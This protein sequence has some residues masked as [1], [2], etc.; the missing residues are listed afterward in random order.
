[1][2][3]ICYALKEEKSQNSSGNQCLHMDVDCNW[4]CNLY[5]IKNVHEVAD[6]LKSLSINGFIVTP[7]SYG[8]ICHHLKRATINRNAK[9][10]INRL[11]APKYRL[12]ISILLIVLELYSNM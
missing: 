5:T 10:E 1:M 11:K 4:I 7:V 2:K 9:R 12:S 8:E 3:N 6:F